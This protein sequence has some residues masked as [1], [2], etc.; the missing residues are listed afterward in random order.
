MIKVGITGGIGSGK[1][2]VCKVFTVLGASVFYA[3]AIGKQLMNTD[4]KLIAQIKNLLGEESYTSQK[5]NNRW[6]AQQVFQNPT[7]LHQLNQIV[8]PAVW[9]AY[10]EWSCKQT[11]KVLL[12]ET[13]I[14]F[15][16]GFAQKHDYN[17]LVYT[18]KELRIQRVLERDNLSKIEVEQRIEN[19]EDDNGKISK[20]DFVIYNDDSKL[21]IPQIIKI[22]NTLTI[23]SSS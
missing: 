9:N 5:L 17:I 18:P 10:E 22:Y 7:L 2:L 3:D 23:K 8:H 13:A 16:S 6:I 11:S 15:E 1:T 12:H 14:L 21:L 19:Q 20:V 4:T